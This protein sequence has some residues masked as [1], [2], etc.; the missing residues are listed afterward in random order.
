MP[1]SKFV[2]FDLGNVLVTF[3]HQIAASQLADAARCPIEHVWNTVFV[4]DLQT[5]F[6]TGLVSDHQYASEINSALGS[7]IPKEHILEAISAIFQPN[8]L[9]LPALELVRAAGVPMGVLSNTCDAHWLWLQRQNWPMLDGWFDQTILSYEVQS[10]KP[11]AGIYE[12][13]ENA[14]G[15]TGSQIFFTDDREENVAA[16]AKRGWATHHFGKADAL[17]V[18]LQN[19]LS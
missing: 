13:S 8:S 2:Y 10:M 12:A 6:E 16:A 14:C 5:R 11:D 18:A 15:L 7:S 4:S 19:W 9:I 3:D 17:L 1:N